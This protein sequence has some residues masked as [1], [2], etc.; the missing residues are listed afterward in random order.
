MFQKPPH[1]NLSDS[2]VIVLRGGSSWPRD[3]ASESL[4]SDVD[5]IYYWNVNVNKFCEFI[6]EAH[7]K[8]IKNMHMK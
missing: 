3:E 4:P 7:N 1:T 6:N 5:S 8:R 2:V